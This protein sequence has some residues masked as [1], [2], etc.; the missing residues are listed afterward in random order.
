MPHTRYYH[1]PASLVR[2]RRR[3]G[4]IVPAAAVVFGLLAVGAHFNVLPWDKPLANAVLE[5]RTSWLEAVVRKVSFLGSNP[6]VFTVAGVAALA[7]ARRCPRVALVIVALALTRPALEFLLKELVGRPRP[8]GARMVRG[9]GPSFPSGHPLATAASWGVLPIVV[10]LYTRRRAV[11]WSV[12]A[13][14]WILAVCVAISRVWLGVHW[15]TDVAAS[16]ILAFIGMTAVEHFVDVV[17]GHGRPA[18]VDAPRPSVD[19]CQL[20][21]AR[22]E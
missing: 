13:G 19:C 2:L 11:W 20:R 7:A 15:P 16:L 4:W 5:T 18:P 22:V 10:A 3:Y 8:D 21:F 1:P 14:V 9:T 17:N 6:V 12:A